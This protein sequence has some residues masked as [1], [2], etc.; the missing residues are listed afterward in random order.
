MSVFTPVNRAELEQF[1]AAY[2]VGQL[3]DFRGIEAGISNTNYFVETG[4]DAN[5]QRWVFTLF[6]DMD[7][8]Q[9]PWFMGLM[10]HLAQRGVPTPAP[11]AR[12]DG[13]GFL[14]EVCSKPAAI[15]QRLPGGDVELPSVSQCHSL[16]VQMARMHLAAAD[17]PLARPN[18]RGA[19]WRQEK[20]AAV[21]GF[22]S[23]EAKSML[24]RE[25]AAQREFVMA[26]LPQ[27]IIHADLFRDNV[28][29]ATDGSRISGLIDF[30][31]A[32]NEALLYDLAVAAND[33]CWA[34]GQP[35]NE[36]WAAMHRGYES[37]RPLE[38]LEKQ[39]W[40]L[41]L[42]AAALRFWVSRLLDWHFPRE[43]ELTWQKDPVVFQK[44]LAAH[45][46]DQAVFSLQ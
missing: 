17:Y 40:P 33:W 22:L 24:E 41:V 13:S 29:G 20:G 9:L 43:G 25:L 4:D 37:V 5:P 26:E 3:I 32:C 2:E 35:I 42:R 34:D 14:T 27:G 7:P 36:N 31:Y 28:L 1:L 10:A 18:C 16:G 12:R 6:E 39:A 8:Q 38:N 30:Y 21:L 45:Q 11:A 19:A 23:G 15:V 46:A 44:I